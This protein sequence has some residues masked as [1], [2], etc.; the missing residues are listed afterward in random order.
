PATAV[1]LRERRRIAVLIGP[2][3]VLGQPVDQRQ[4]WVAQCLSEQRLKVWSGIRTEPDQQFADTGVGKSGIEKSG[5]EGKWRQS[6]DGKR[7]ELKDL[8]ARELKGA[9]TNK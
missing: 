4:G 2:T 8:K 3:P 9:A 5:E 6:S 7:C 1:G